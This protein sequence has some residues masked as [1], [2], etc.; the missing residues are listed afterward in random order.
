MATNSASVVFP[1][2]EPVLRDCIDTLSRVA[3]YRLPH[4]LN[5]RLLWLSENKEV[6]DEAQRDELAALVELADHRSL[7]KVQARALLDQL[8]RMYPELV[9][10]QL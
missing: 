10:G 4:A 1:Q 9:N 6:L 8:T 7:D 2:E 5:Q 3:S